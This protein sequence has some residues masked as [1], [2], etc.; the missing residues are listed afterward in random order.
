MQSGW[1][2][3]AC[4]LVCMY[5]P[6][7][8]TV[9]A[10][11]MWHELFAAPPQTFQLVPQP[12][13]PAPTVTQAQGLTA[14]GG[15]TL[16]VQ[17]GR[18]ELAITGTDPTP[19]DPASFGTVTEPALAVADA[20]NRLAKLPQP[21]VRLGLVLEAAKPARTA[22]E[23]N[24]ILR[25]EVAPLG[26]LPAGTLD[27]QFGMNRRKMVESFEINRLIRWGIGTLQTFQFNVVGPGVVV[28]GS[29]AP[30]TVVE[31]HFANVVCDMNTVPLPGAAPLPPTSLP[32]LWT[33]LAAEG[34]AALS[35]GYALFI[36]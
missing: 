34:E 4:K 33:A 5:H 10:S 35:N 8:S 3:T 20:I 14:F 31:K 17:P 12:G 25:A 2:V 15:A 29:Q 21:M 16:V 7:H 13:H 19:H 18:L 27:L 32:R 6:T 30:F 23:A 36:D 1:A 28:G 26:Q 22:E 24:D 11:G 9:D